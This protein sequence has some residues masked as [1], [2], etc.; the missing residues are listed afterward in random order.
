M[1]SSDDK[2]F[3]RKATGLVRT[4]GLLDI[5][6]FNSWINPCTGMFTSFVLIYAF[7]WP[8]ANLFLG[9][10]I[11]TIGAT[12]QTLVYA[13]FVSTM[14]RAGGEYVW[15]SRTLPWPIIGYV[16][17]LVGWC[18]VLPIWCVLEAVGLSGLYLQPMAAA[19]GNMD[20]ALWF[21]TPDGVFMSSI[22]V[23]V[24]IVL[25]TVAGMKWCGRLMSSSY[26]VG[27]LISAIVIT[28]VLLSFT[29][30]QFIAAHDSFYAKNLGI[31]GAYQAVIDEAKVAW[32][33]PI[34]GLGEWTW[35][36]TLSFVALLA[37]AN[38]WSMWGAPLYGEVRGASEMKVSFLSMGG[39]NLLN[40]G[41]LVILLL[42]WIRLVGYDFFQASNL[43]YGT[44]VFSGFDPTAA[45]LLYQGTK[46]WPMLWPSPLVVVLQITGNAFITIVLGI[47]VTYYALVLW[48]LGYLPAIRILFAMAFDR[49]LPS[50]VAGL[51][52]TRKIPIV[53][54]AVIVAFGLA[55]AA[56]YIYVPGFVTLTMMGT[57]VLVISFIATSL[58][59]IVLPRRLPAL[60]N[61]SVAS[62][63]KIGRIP[64][65]SIAGIIS[66][67]F[68]GWIIYKWISDPTFGV[69]V[70]IS[71]AYFLAYY[72]GAI[73]LY[74]V[75]KSYRKR[76]G[77]D[78]NLIHREVP[79]E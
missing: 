52:T 22:V 10:L 43:L 31:S 7:F 79:V 23:I 37:Y 66:S 51:Y 17:P 4:W 33:W 12:F 71:A 63:Y 27:G 56:L 29:Q 21:M 6:A 62:K 42:A 38:A 25:V 72:I 46:V 20:A 48:C 5:L 14:P 30:S 60:W 2:L 41:L 49:V 45:S 8:G 35:A 18:M 13:M 69:A 11:G 53:G 9:I 76:Q 19:L 68:F 55:N 1:A 16:L 50:P 15:M 3:L 58:T 74:L 54:L 57:V 28:I 40:T 24:V 34:Y 77:I 39:S 75:M 70:P 32:Q 67:F 65:V 64:L 47:L 26:V 73:I 61:A 78:I 44:F 36:P 59:A